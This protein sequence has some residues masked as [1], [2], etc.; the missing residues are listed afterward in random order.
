MEEF[1][2][3]T[4]W[5]FINSATQRDVAR[6]GLSPDVPI[7]GPDAPSDIK[8][9]DFSQ[10][11]SFVEFKFKASADPFIDRPRVEGVPASRNGTSFEQN[12]VEAKRIRGQLGSYVAAIAG[13][14]FRLRVFAVLIFGKF[15]RLMCWDR[16]ATVITEKFDY[17]EK[18]YLAQFLLSYCSLEPE[19][20]GLDPTVRALTAKELQIV[21]TLDC[22]ND[23]ADRNRHHREFRLMK[24]P[25]RDTTTE[26]DF[27][28]S[29]PPKYSYRSPFGRATRPMRAYDMLKKKVVFV[30]DYWRPDSPE[31]EKE[32]DI[33]RSL[34]RAQ[35][36]YIAPFGV[37]N[38]V[39]NFRTHIQRYR[40]H[41]WACETVRFSGLVLYRMS[42]DKLGDDLVEFESTHELA[43]V[44][45]HAM[46]GMRSNLHF[47]I[48]RLFIDG[49]QLTTSPF[50]KLRYCIAISVLEISSLTITGMASLLIG[51]S[52]SGPISRRLHGDHKEQFVFSSFFASYLLTFAF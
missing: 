20:R 35:V 46:T 48:I 51:I 3:A 21:N 18:P 2:P 28:I 6:D 31:I 45:S 44:I 30:K 42:L 26:H 49:S 22:L 33:Y 5:Q 47:N 19:Q 23:L 8:G 14:Q 25:D 17:T 36:P 29:Y 7:Y 34:E 9:P 15:A 38:D 13:S 43:K 32:G 11:D 12:S 1:S 37:G 40:E 52:A 16:S 10:M 50:T 27:L 4:K 39:R 41:V 24:I